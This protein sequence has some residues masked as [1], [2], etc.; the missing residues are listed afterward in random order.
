MDLGR[1]DPL[2]AVGALLHHPAAAHRDVR[3]ASEL[4][5]LGLE[6]GIE[7]EVE[8]ADLV[9]AIVGAVPGADAAVVDHGVD[10]F[11]R[12]H[13]RPHGTDLLARGVFTMLAGHRLEVGAGR[14]QVA[15]EVGVD[16][17]PLHV[18]PDLD[19]LLADDGDVVLRV[20]GDDAG[21]AADA[22]VHVDGHAPG[23]LVVDIRR[24]HALVGLGILA[25]LALVG[26]IGILFKLLERGVADDAPG[27]GLVGLKGMGPSAGAAGQ[28]RTVVVVVALGVG[29]LVD[30]GGLGD[31]RPGG[32]QRR[33]RRTDRV[34]VEARPAAD[35]SR[36]AASVA[37]IDGD[38][39]VGMA[40]NDQNGGLDLLAVQRDLDDIRLLELVFDQSGVADQRG[41]VPGEVGDRL[42]QLLQPADI[43]VAPVVERGIRAEDD[44][45]RIGGGRGRSLQGAG[46]GR[47]RLRLVGGALDESVVQRLPPV[48]LEVA[49]GRER[50]LPGG[51]HRLVGRNQGLVDQHRLDHL[52]GR[53][54]AVER[55]DHR[56]DDGH[57]AV[58]GPGV[59]PGFQIVGAV[60]VPLGDR[61]RLVDM[62][63]QMHKGVDLGEGG[64]EAEVG[65]G[66]VDRID[67][68]RQQP[69]DLAGVHVGDQRPEVLV[70]P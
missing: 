56:L 63:A 36:L 26:E 62:R 21:V 25:A 16:P 38:A 3:I 14:G 42:G 23:V 43:G 11:R 28:L 33:G 64:L 49:L 30:V 40:G 27:L 5:A 54:A 57:H 59:G 18:A 44:L 31:R 9:R 53:L 69:L 13:G 17:E 41:V 15:L 2:D 37:E 70:L 66:G 29:E 61:P 1:A 35:P 51:A 68:E 58:I 60:D 48:R 19:L 6:V 12:V 52:V 47:Y 46:P 45:D 10:A 22:G 7:K 39:V 4:V 34:G 20:A 24:E 55:I 65:G 67:V 32:E 50:R 8:P